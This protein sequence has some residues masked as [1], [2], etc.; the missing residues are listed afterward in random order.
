MLNKTPNPKCTCVLDVL[1]AS[2]SQ[3]G[4]IAL[5]SVAIV[6]A[7]NEPDFCAVQCLLVWSSFETLRPNARPAHE[8]ML[9]CVFLSR[10]LFDWYRQCT[11][12]DLPTV[13]KRHAH[14]RTTLTLPPAIVAGGCVYTTFVVH[15]KF[16]RQPDREQ[17]GFLQQTPAKM[18]CVC[19]RAP[20]EVQPML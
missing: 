1:Y 10:A 14:T 5:F 3:F 19:A 13:G 4:I 9:A 7:Q 20:H 18:M 17:V 2:F 12:V 8:I 6:T 15:Q 16:Y 11:T